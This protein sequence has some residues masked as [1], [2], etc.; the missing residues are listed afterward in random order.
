MVQSIESGERF[1][2]SVGEY[3]SYGNNGICKVSEICMMQLTKNMPKKEYYVL[4]PLYE[5]LKN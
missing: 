3:I 5:A 1:L 2:F 4:Q